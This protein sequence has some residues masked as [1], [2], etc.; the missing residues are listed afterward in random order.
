VRVSFGHFFDPHYFQAT[1]ANVLFSGVCFW[2]IKWSYFFEKN[3]GQ[4]KLPINK[5]KV[6]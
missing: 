4:A 5:N 6:Q 3:K 2:R 1:K